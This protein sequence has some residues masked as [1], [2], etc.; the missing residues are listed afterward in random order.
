MLIAIP[1]VLDAAG[2]ARLRAL[3]DAAE[4]VDG[5]A[6]SGAQSALAK[7]NR[8]LPAV[9]RRGVAA[10]GVSAVVQPL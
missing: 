3:I 5:T 10:Q 1:D 8:Q 9:R 4:W 7:R 6:T 2:V